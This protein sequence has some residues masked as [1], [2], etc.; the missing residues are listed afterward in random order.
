MITSSYYQKRYFYKVRVNN[1][2]YNTRPDFN[3]FSDIARDLDLTH[4]NYTT[5][6]GSQELYT[7]ADKGEIG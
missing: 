5:Y 6:T 7:E 3:E 2:E 4:I 1:D